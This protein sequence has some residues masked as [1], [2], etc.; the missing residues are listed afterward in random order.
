MLAVGNNM[1]YINLQRAIAL[2]MSALTEALDRVLDRHVALNPNFASALLPGL[3]REKILEMTQDIPHPIPEELIEIYEWHNGSDPCVYADFIPCFEFKS[4]E[5]GIEYFKDN[6]CQHNY[7]KT[8][9]NWIAIM[10]CNGDAQLVVIL[11]GDTN[12]SPVWCR[13]LELGVY[14][15]CF[16]SLT[17]MIQ[18]ISS[19]FEEGL[20][21]YGSASTPIRGRNYDRYCKIHKKYN[22]TASP[23]RELYGYCQD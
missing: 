4:L 14:E 19:L 17:T 16:D 13:D 10:D 5:H 7:D 6:W 21:Y 15:Q 23:I 3:S 9:S 18:T 22:Y 2:N 1:G 20:H 11:G 12:T 8:K